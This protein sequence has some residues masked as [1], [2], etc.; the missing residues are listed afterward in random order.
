MWV[1][2]HEQRLVGGD[3]YAS[4]PIDAVVNHPLI[5]SGVDEPDAVIRRIGKINFIARRDGEVMGLHALRDNGLLAVR[6]VCDDPLA[7]VLAGVKPP[8][9]AA[10]D[11]MRAAAVLFPNRD[12]AVGVA[13]TCAGRSWSGGSIMENRRSRTLTLRQALDLRH[14]PNFDSS[15]AHFCTNS[16]HRFRSVGLLPQPKRVPRRRGDS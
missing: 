8:V 5:P 13:T 2:D 4:R 1:V 9:R 11:S 15:G 6:R 3:A 12:P 7:V 10:N 16:F 14:R